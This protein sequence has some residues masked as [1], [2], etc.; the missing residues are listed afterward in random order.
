MQS[1]FVVRDPRA[2]LRPAPPCPFA[3]SVHP[4]PFLMVVASGRGALADVLSAVELLAAVA[5]R[6]GH[7]RAL[8]DL[9]GVEIALSPIDQLTLRTHIAYALQRFERVASVV[10]APYRVGGGHQGAQVG[11]SNIRTF[12]ALNHAIEWVQDYSLRHSA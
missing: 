5:A 8:L 7:A 2:G 9:T 4:G 11:G 12:A 1:Q 10:P 3:L 6:D